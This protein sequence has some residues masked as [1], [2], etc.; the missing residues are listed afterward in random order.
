MP[1][2]AILSDSQ[3]VDVINF[4]VEKWGAKP[5]KGEKQAARRREAEQ[6]Q[7]AAHPTGEPAWGV[8]FIGY[9]APCLPA[10]PGGVD[11]I[12]LKAAYPSRFNTRLQTQI[13][14]SYAS[15]NQ[16]SSSRV[17]RKCTGCWM[18]VDK[19][20]CAQTSKVNGGASRVLVYM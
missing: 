10:V 12:H 19:C 7:V 3:K 17:D 14:A 8:Q 9:P 1:S 2:Q 4:V 13:E 16:L 6:Q 11:L 18:M 20:F 15:R 5:K